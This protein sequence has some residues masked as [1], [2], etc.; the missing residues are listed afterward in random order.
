MTSLFTGDPSTL[1]WLGDVSGETISQLLVLAKLAY[2]GTKEDRLIFYEQS[3]T[4]QTLGRVWS[5]YMHVCGVR[6]MC[7]SVC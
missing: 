1:L 7:V 6:S 3:G 4:F 2:D 5:S